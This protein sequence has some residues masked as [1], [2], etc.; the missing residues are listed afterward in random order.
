MEAPADLHDILAWLR[1]GRWNAAHDHVQRHEGLLAAWLHGLLHLQEGDLE[2]AENWYERAGRRFR[3]R[4]TFE[5]EL[6]RF[7]AALTNG[8]AP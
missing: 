6:A 7:E 1:E 5:E 3:Q 8:T 4:G 2:D